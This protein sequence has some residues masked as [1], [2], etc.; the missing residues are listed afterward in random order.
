[1]E[2]AVIEEN[3]PAAPAVSAIVL[4]AG[5]SRRMGE[6]N[7]KLLL[8]LRG[9]PLVAHVVETLMQTSI[10]ACIVVLGHEANVVKQVLK[11][12]PVTFVVNDR[13]EMGMGSSIHA[14]IKAVSNDARGYMVCLSDMPFITA[15]EYNALIKTFCTCYA[16]D[17]KTIVVPV[18]EGK[19]GNPVIL[20]A[21]HAPAMLSHKG[22]GGCKPVIQENSK[23]LRACKMPNNH[24]L[25]D[26]DTPE[27]FSAIS[28]E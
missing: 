16:A 8:P 13:Y 7:N 15:M 25:R 1:M 2:D 12:Y 6:D 3:E 17:P 11:D 4:A 20:S 26:I 21:Q 9:R 5:E 23:H 24:V 28:G 10:D 27:N 22:K 14:G 19:R 18:F